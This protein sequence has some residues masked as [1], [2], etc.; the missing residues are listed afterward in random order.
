MS[1]CQSNLDE[2]QLNQLQNFLIDHM[3]DAACMPLDVCHGFLTAMLSG[4]RST[5]PV[6]WMPMVLGKVEFEDEELSVE[7][8]DLLLKLAK[9]IE[10][11]LAHS[12]YA[13]MIL[14]K[15]A[16]LGDPLPLPYGWCQGYLI[17]MGVQGESIRDEAMHDE[18]ASS[19]L[20]PILAF[21]MYEDEQM[22][23][24]P[25]EVAHRQAAMELGVSAMSL[26]HWWN[27]DKDEK[28]SPGLGFEVH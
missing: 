17:G 7:I 11:D 21:M 1:S 15:P 23:N 25:D 12:H 20:S 28:E 27:D 6:E 19:F 2:Q 10:H 24:P 13:P 8:S 4:P 14:Y 5:T 16:D 18:Q 3:D 9:D 22:N 26:F